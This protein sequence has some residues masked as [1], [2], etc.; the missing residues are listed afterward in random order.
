MFLL[1]SE[2]AGKSTFVFALNPADMD[3][4]G[5]VR[6]LHLVPVSRLSI[7][8]G[9]SLLY[10]VPGKIACLRLSLGRTFCAVCSWRKKSTEMFGAF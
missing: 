4:I 3:G 9:S 7:L 6:L 8:W 5:S 2:N 1:P 10:V